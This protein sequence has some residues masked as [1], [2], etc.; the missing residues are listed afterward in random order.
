LVQTSCLNFGSDL[1]HLL[2]LLHLYV[3]TCCTLVMTQF[4]F[5]SGMAGRYL[6][7]IECGLGEFQMVTP[8]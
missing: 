5:H 1:E 7:F 6:H 4:K 2:G 8:S 3:L